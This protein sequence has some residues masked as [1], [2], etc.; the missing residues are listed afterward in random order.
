[1]HISLIR[2]KKKKENTPQQL[3][4]VTSPPLSYIQMC[5]PWRSLHTF[6][7]KL[8]YSY[9]HC[10]MSANIWHSPNSLRICSTSQHPQ[11]ACIDIT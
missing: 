9:I 7:I 8:S 1:M 2:Q 3:S 5:L 11:T 6:L 4:L 10:G